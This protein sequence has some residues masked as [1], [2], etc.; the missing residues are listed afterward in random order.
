M[1]INLPIV[2]SILA[3][4]LTFSQLIPQL[5]KTYKTKRVKDLSIHTILIIFLSNVLWFIHGLY[6][7]DITLIF[8][9][10]VSSI[11]SFLMLV[12]YFIHN[13]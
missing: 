10:I 4:V 8:S 3:P 6:I 11:I 2:V 7:H 13:K 9:G 1:N 5:Y 12:L